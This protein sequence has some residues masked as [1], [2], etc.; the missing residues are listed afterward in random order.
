MAPAEPCLHALSMSSRNGSSRSEH[1]HVTAQVAAAERFAK[2]I[3]VAFAVCDEARTPLSEVQKIAIIEA[4]LL[5]F[6]GFQGQIDSL[7]GI[8]D[9]L[10][11]LR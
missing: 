11:S 4:A 5:E 1:A 7:A 6:D 2:A 8:G 3:V 9:L 10:R